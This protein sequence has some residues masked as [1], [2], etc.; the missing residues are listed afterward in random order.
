MHERIRIL[1]LADAHSI[2]TEKWIEGLA[3]DP[4]FDFYIINLNSDLTRESVKNH[5]RVIQVF[6]VAR[7]KVK[8]QGGNFG[9]LLKVPKIYSISKAINPHVISTVF[10]TSYGMIGSLIKGKKQKLFHYLIGTDVMVTATKNL[11]YRMAA[12]F[13]LARADLIMS[14][15]N[16]IT[17]KVKTIHQSAIKNLFTMQYGVRQ[18]LLTTRTEQ[19][20]IFDFVSNRAWV[21]NSNIE[22]ILEIFAKL[23]G[24]RSLQL[25]GGGGTLADTINTLAK[26]TSGVTLRGIVDHASLVKMV[27][28][29]RFFLSWTNSDGAA[30]SLMEAM[31]IGCVPIVSDTTP[32]R[33]WI[34]HQVNGFMIPLGKNQEIFEI[35]SSALSQ[36]YS[37]LEKMIAIN[38][39]IIKERGCFEAN[40]GFVC[41]KIDNILSSKPATT[42]LSTNAVKDL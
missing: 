26:A 38:R 6:E 21:P 34:Q 37:V 13:S 2:H 11:A 16:A 3:L 24:E 42:M 1:V 35:V 36:P 22:L 17:N 15:S 25:I 31:A 23:P 41:Q 7:R 27:A 4:R 10:L 9:Y 32:N 12:K 20:K 28:Q 40:M 18:E 33:E 8:T 39:S 14:A 19:Q 30:L 29:S 5:P